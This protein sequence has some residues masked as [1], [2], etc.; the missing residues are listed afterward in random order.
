LGGN[1]LNRLTKSNI[2]VKSYQKFQ[3]K[4][5]RE[6]KTMLKETKLI[7]C[8]NSLHY[9]EKTTYDVII[10]DEIETL[11]D[12][13][14]G[15]FMAKHKAKNFDTLIHLLKT[16]KTVIFLDA[17]ITKKTIDFINSIEKGLFR[18]D[19]STPIIKIYNR[20]ENPITR[21]IKFVKK[22]EIMLADS[23]D[24]IKQGFKIF[25]FYPYKKM[26]EYPSMENLYKTIENATGKTGI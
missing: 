5:H 10:I 8:A 19:S 1:T 13:F 2:E 3:T 4:H 22:W 11:L 24:K 20:K 14:L 16:A 17:F 15:D 23:I 6:E 18:P 12:K 9:L 26:G 25:I 21:T 7:I